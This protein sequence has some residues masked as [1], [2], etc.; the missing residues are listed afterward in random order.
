VA[1]LQLARPTA[2]V[3][4]GFL[5]AVIPEQPIAF[6][7]EYLLRADRQS[8]H[9]LL[10]HLALGLVLL[11]HDVHF[12]PS[13]AVRLLQQP[14]AELLILLARARQHGDETA[15]LASDVVHVLGTGQL[16]VGNIEKVGTS[17]QLAEHV[18][19]LL[20][21][22][23]VGGVAAGRSKIDGNS[24][25]FGHRENI[26]QLL[27]I[28]AMVFTVTE[29]DGQG[30]PAMQTTLLV[31]GIVGSVKGDGGGIVVEFLQTELEFINQLSN[32]G[33]DQVGFQAVKQAI[34]ATSEAVVVE[35]LEFMRLQIQQVGCVASRPLTDAVNRLA[36]DKNIAD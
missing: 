32:D 24:T 19:G 35:E 18:P 26:K 36:G 5:A 28:G 14:L 22:G 23:V 33:H 25:I 17:H 4:L 15:L 10:D 31:R 2:S 27:Q 30:G 29:R 11:R 34:E 1:T 20:M 12:L 8:V 7:A 6:L 9:R 3:V 16:T 21:R 13:D